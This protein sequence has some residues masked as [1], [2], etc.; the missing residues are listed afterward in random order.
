MRDLLERLRRRARALSRSAASRAQQAAQ[1][2]IDDCVAQHAALRL[3]RPDA[4]LE[5]LLL[6]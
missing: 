4:G 6:G 3:Q 5:P 2:G 1:R